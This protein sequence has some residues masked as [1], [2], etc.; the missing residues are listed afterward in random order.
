MNWLR[1]HWKRV[2]IITITVLLLVAGGLAAFVYLRADSAVKSVAKSGTAVDLLTPQALNG[3]QTGT[4]NILI[5]GNS[6]DDADHGGAE[7]TDSIMVANYKLTTKK[8]T[9]ISVPRDLYVSIDGGFAKINAVYEMGGMDQLKTT[10]EQVTGLTINH[11]VL[12][13]YAAF[14]QMIDAVGGI[15]VTIAADDP[16]GIYDP[17]IGY[18]I[19]NGSHHLNGSDALLLIRCRNDP[20]YDGRVPYGLSGGD[21]DRA[22]NQRMIV[23]AL[24]QRVNSNATLSSPSAMER[25]IESLSGNVKSDLTVSQIR[26]VYDIG[27][28]VLVTS[29]ISVRGTD[30]S[31]LLADYNNTPSGDALIPAAGIGDYTAI[32]DYIAKQLQ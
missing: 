3:E 4:V 21:F 26:R 23:Q 17:M 6:V 22:S 7:L 25:I 12:I 14:K 1:R 30:D 31:L 10:V 24:L 18:S 19:T 13:N 9:L 29:S 32:Q 2:L 5:A 16:R 15:D 20:T 28:E 11:Q 8:L 27:K